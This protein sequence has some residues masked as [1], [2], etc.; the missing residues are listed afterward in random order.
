[1]TKPLRIVPWVVSEDLQ[2]IYDYHRAFSAAKAERIVLEFDRIIAALEVNPL[3]L[4]AREGGWRIYPFS[5]GTD[6][7]YYFE[8]ETLWLVTGL[9]HARRHPGWIA[10]RLH[11]RLGSRPS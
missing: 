8:M 11:E 6:L 7:L 2:G 3:L 1:M 5:E 9:F 10:E 4:H